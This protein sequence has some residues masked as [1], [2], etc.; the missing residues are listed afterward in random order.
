[1][2]HYTRGLLA[3]SPEQKLS[4]LN[5]AVKLDPR[6]SQAWFR[7]GKM[8][9]ENKE[10]R[11]AVASLAK[12]S[13]DDSHHREATYYLGLSR[14]MLRDYAGAQQA[15]EAVASEVPLNEVW[16]NL[17]AA[18]L[19]RNLPGAVESFQKALE[20]D[21]MD[22]DYHF[23]LGLALYRQGKMSAAAESFRAVLDR[24]P[25]DAEAM[26]MLGRS[27][28]Q[29]ANKKPPQ[30]DA[31]ERL[32]DDYEESAYLQLKAVLERPKQ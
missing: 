3:V 7:L 11:T 26:G 24:D 20:G 12:V 22:P 8:Q 25:D 28:K 9:W 6:Y 14:Y 17:G 13:P 21:P 27:L 31:Q 16:N 29:T 4:L 10:Y 19:R 15:F 30:P 32:K 2:E 23:N 18:Q 5:Q 1:M